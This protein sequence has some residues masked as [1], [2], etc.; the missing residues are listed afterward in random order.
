MV[1]NADESHPSQAEGED[2]SADTP[3]E[4]LASAGQPS[5]AEG[6]DPR[7]EVHEVLEP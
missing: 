3:I 2:P 7:D 4:V 1:K 6:E 5:Q